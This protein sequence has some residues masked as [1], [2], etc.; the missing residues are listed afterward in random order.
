M[1]STM[2]NWVYVNLAVD[3]R[4]RSRNLPRSYLQQSRCMRIKR[5]VW[6]TCPRGSACEIR[7]GLIYLP[8]ALGHVLRT[9]LCVAYYK[10]GYYSCTYGPVLMGSYPTCSLKSVRAVYISPHDVSCRLGSLHTKASS[11]SG[12]LLTIPVLS[13]SEL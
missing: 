10:E 11:T 3:L 8:H 6:G 13:G 4:G 9:I 2:S 12:R 1:V 5:P 7:A